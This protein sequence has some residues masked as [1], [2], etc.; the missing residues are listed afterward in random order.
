MLELRRWLP[1]SLAPW[2][3]EGVTVYG[4]VSGDSHERMRDASPALEQSV[5]AAR[6][7]IG[8]WYWDGEEEA[9]R[10]AIAEDEA[11]I[12]HPGLPPAREILAAIVEYSHL[13][14]PNFSTDMPYDYYLFL[15]RDADLHFIYMQDR[16]SGVD[17]L[18]FVDGHAD[19]ERAMTGAIGLLQELFS[20]EWAIGVPEMIEFGVLDRDAVESILRASPAFKESRADLT[21]EEWE[22]LM[23]AGSRST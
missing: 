19:R 12:T 17:I 2:E 9:T 15:L 21:D 22:E 3:Y 10:Q 6:L 14:S 7:T 11:A 20:V 4:P 23:G 8:R 13:F 18:G 5:L 1:A 16:N